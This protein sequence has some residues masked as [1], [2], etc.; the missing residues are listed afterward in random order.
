MSDVKRLHD[1]DFV[2]WS[3]QQAQ[4]LR[5]VARAGSNE[6]LDWENLAEE[7]EGLGISQRSAMQSQIRRIIRHLL[8]LQFSQARDPRR[9]WIESINDARGEVEHLLETSPSLRTSLAG[10]LD[11][12]TGRAIRQ[13]VQDLRA[14]GEIGEEAA[15]LRTARYTA[16]QVLGEWFPG[17]PNP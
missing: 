3:A 15:V 9:G 10:D 1:E 2:L 8:K 14:Y 11:A 13:A 5:A 17:D 6:L 4:A 12:E 7:I 16:E